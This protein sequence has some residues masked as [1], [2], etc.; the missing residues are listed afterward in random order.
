MGPAT[1]VG[2]RGLKECVLIRPTTTMGKAVNI[3]TLYT[4]W[5]KEVKIDLTTHSRRAGDTVPP[6]LL[7]F[8][9][10]LI[11]PKLGRGNTSNINDHHVSQN[12]PR[13]GHTCAGSA[14]N[15]NGGES[16]RACT[17]PCLQRPAGQAV[18]PPPSDLGR[19]L[20]KYSEEGGLTPTPRVP[21]QTGPRSQYCIGFLIEDHGCSQHN[22]RRM[23][24][25]L[26]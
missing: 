11:A 24:P 1:C 16:T 20:S 12:E 7:N 4:E 19:I 2:N 10:H 23:H 8:P 14:L 21:N 15:I 9:A 26:A 5:L 22:C 17:H 25:A 18:L 13:Q 3:T 6:I